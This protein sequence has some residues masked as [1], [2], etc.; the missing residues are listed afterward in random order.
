MADDFQLWLANL[1]GRE[2]ASPNGGD[3]NITINWLA[4][5]SPKR[6]RLRQKLTLNEKGNTALHVALAERNESRARDLIDKGADVN[7]KND[8]GNTPLHLAV[9]ER[10][11]A[12]VKLLVDN[13][14]DVTVKNNLGEAPFD[15]VVEAKPKQAT[16]SAPNRRKRY[17]EPE[18]PLLHLIGGSHLA[19]A[20]GGLI[21]GEGGHDVATLSPQTNAALN[22]ASVLLELAARKLTGAK[23][24]SASQVPLGKDEYMSAKLDAIDGTL[25]R[26]LNKFA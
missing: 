13:G 26:A 5:P 16:T 19:S 11:P 14:A 8:K 1:L 20:R 12:I 24:I 17:V 4:P 15:E 21:A 22:D 25:S 9:Q 7:A 23:Q 3:I 10:F 6:P 18:K 2:M